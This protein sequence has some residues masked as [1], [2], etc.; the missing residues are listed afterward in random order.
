MSQC[1]ACGQPFSAT[2]ATARF[3]STACRQCA[4]R[5]RLAAESEPAGDGPLVTAVRAELACIGHLDTANGQSRGAVGQGHRTPPVRGAC[6]RNCA[7]CSVT[8]TSGP[9]RGA[10]ALRRAERP[11]LDPRTG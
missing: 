8:A 10:D 6:P 2:R 5:D 11:G 4:H 7:R 9:P 1:E 3:C